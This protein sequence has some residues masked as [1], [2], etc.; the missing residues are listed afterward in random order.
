MQKF[1]LHFNEIDKTSLPIVG[2]K[3]ANLW[4]M[5]KAGFPIPKWFCITTEAYKTI[6][7]QDN[8]LDN[9]ITKLDILDSN[10]L[11]KT[12]EIGALIR[13]HIKSLP[14]PI[15]I[16]ESIIKI[17]QKIWPDKNYA[18]RSSATAEDLPGASFAGQQDT[19][20]NI[21]WE[22]Q[23]LESVKNCWAS[24]FTDRAISYRRKNN[25][26]HKSVYLSVVVQEMI[27]S[28][29]SGIMFTADPVSGKRN[30]ISINASFGLWEALVG[31]LVKSDLYQVSES[32]II[33]KEISDK[34]VQITSLENGWTVQSEIDTEKQLL[35]SLSD[36]QIIELAKLG[37]KI[38]DHY[39]IPQDIEWCLK[40]NEFYVVQSRPIT[41]LYPLPS[42]I[43]EWLHFFFS[44]G[45]LQM[46]TEAMKP[47]GFSVFQTISQYV[48]KIFLMKNPITI[49][50][51][52]RL[53]V[54]MMNILQY[55]IFQKNLPEI[56]INIDESASKIL[57]E[58]MKQDDF[59]MIKTKRLSFRRVKIITKFVLFEIKLFFF[60]KFE[61]MFAE[62]N[63]AI[64]NTIITFRKDL[65]QTPTIEKIQKIKSFIQGVPRKILETKIIRYMPLAIWSYKLLGIFSKRWLWDTNE[66]DA[67]GKAP[68]GNVTTE[69]GLV[70]GDLGDLVQKNPL[71]KSYLEIAD[72]ENFWEN[73]EKIEWWKDFTN[74]LHQFFDKYGMRCTWEIDIT[75]PRWKEEP[76]KVASLILKSIPLSSWANAKDPF[77]PDKL[78]KQSLRDSSLHSEWQEPGQHR[79]D[80]L[81]S[82]EEWLKASE[83]LLDRIKKTRF[84]FLKAMFM[85]RLI[86]VHRSTI[87]V[88]EHPKYFIINI[89]D[90]IKSSILEEAN[91]LVAL[92]ILESTEDIYYFTLDEIEEIL[93]TNRVNTDLLKERKVK[94]AQDKDL[95]PPRVFTGDGE[96][97]QAKPNTNLPV[98]ALSWTAASAWIIEW[99]ARV[100]KRLE[101]ANLQKWDILVTAYT[102]PAW[103]TLFSIAWAVVTE[104]WW[105]LTHWAVVARE[106]WI[107]AVVW[108]DDAT[109]KIVDGDRIRVN[110][111]EGYVEVVR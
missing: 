17:W 111:T 66:V 9:L 67:I 35:Q 92:H 106:Y 100:I 7:T 73:L 48:V 69:M 11:E 20:L 97:L 52:G 16:K 88:R 5:T 27:F 46:M 62:L 12:K 79:K 68:E 33:K 86:Y 109:K 83:I 23:I 31:G 32:K 40:D 13:K 34:K 36:E 93:K 89:F 18:V 85:K 74:S 94:Y 102:D 28:D 15:E 59:K 49:E 91:K 39:G 70:I 61:N 26:H 38:Q 75:R 10:D 56:L 78:N 43:S 60:S 55:K 101:D 44:I 57:K 71:I 53:Y 22:E 65:E 1:V 110:W 25:F 42:E 54:D 90:V 3:W 6:T 51:W 30:T 82:R 45:H 29:V 37:K 105:L 21:R 4:E 64:S 8:I 24:L 72:N 99:R 58:F 81:A 76:A 95:R 103:T 84:W 77:T 41:S 63:Q 47:L 108:V 104:V 19:Y 98:W 14:I 87:G 50:A 107:P 96:I 2:G 80:F